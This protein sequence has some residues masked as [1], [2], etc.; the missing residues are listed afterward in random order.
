MNAA[1]TKGRHD[2][3]EYAR[4]LQL[5]FVIQASLISGEDSEHACRLIGELMGHDAEATH[6]DNETGTDHASTTR[7]LLYQDFLNHSASVDLGSSKQ[8]I[9]RFTTDVAGRDDYTSGFVAGFV[10]AC[11]PWHLILHEFR[12]T[13]QVTQSDF[14]A[15]AT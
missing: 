15:D 5:Q 3:H 4:C 8:P 11:K 1:T 10:A 12:A 14:V 6:R 2:G 9:E 7:A 13:G